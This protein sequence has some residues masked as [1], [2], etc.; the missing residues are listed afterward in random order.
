MEMKW[1]QGVQGKNGKI[2]RFSDRRSSTNRQSDPEVSLR[3]VL[4]K[5]SSD[6]GSRIFW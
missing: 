4:V 1:N 5:T 2:S 3:R 6:F